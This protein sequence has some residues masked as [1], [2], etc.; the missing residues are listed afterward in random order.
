MWEVKTFFQAHLHL[1]SYRLTE[2]LKC[3]QTPTGTLFIVWIYFNAYGKSSNVVII[4]SI[5]VSQKIG[6]NY[7]VGAMQPFWSHN[8]SRRSKKNYKPKWESN[9]WSRNIKSTHN[10]FPLLTVNRYTTTAILLRLIGLIYP[11]T[12][13]PLIIKI[14]DTPC[15]SAGPKK[16]KKIR[17]VIHVMLYNSRIHNLY[18]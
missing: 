11:S 10:H 8:W 1:Q 7:C 4:I 13:Q 17:A 5:L 14:I 16:T 6:V 2:L 9:P 15:S 18:I 3:I 12:N